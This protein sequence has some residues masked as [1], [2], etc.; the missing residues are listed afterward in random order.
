MEVDLEFAGS[1]NPVLVEPGFTAWLT[2]PAQSALL[3]SRRS[4]SA[5]KE[6]CASLEREYCR[7]PSHLRRAMEE[8]RDV[9]KRGNVAS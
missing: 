3:R 8:Q 9:S 6:S 7:C 5:E 1:V 4:S 2:M